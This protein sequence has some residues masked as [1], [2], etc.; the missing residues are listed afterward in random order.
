MSDEGV[1]GD[2]VVVQPEAEEEILEALHW[3]EGRARGLGADSPWPLRLACQLF[4]G[5]QR[6]MGKTMARYAVLSCGGFPTASSTCSTGRRWSSSRV[7]MRAGSRD[8]GRSAP[9]D[10]AEKDY[11]TGDQ[12]PHLA[13]VTKPLALHTERPWVGRRTFRPRFWHRTTEWP[14]KGVAEATA[15]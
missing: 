1:A 14:W 3:Y 2:Q 5:T 4:R 15:G 8:G 9:G 10:T 7:S 11:S 13:S 12:A 6:P